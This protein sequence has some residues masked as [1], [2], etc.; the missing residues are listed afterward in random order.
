MYGKTYISLQKVPIMR[1]T[2][3]THF[4]A[5]TKTYLDAVLDDHEEVIINRGNASAVL[6]S[7]E[8]Y[9]SIKETEYLMQSPQMDDVIRK[10][11]EDARSGNFIEVD[12]DEL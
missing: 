11:L 9:N 7:L 1:C 10:G 8:D 3:A 6:M 2:T 4:R 5:N 12:P